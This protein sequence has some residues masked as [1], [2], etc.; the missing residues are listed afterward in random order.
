MG[1]SLSQFSNR[2]RLQGFLDLSQNREQYSLTEA[3]LESGFGS[4]PQFH[5]VFRQAMNYSLAQHHR[6]IHGKKK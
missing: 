3:A 5:R 6:R 4:Y 2:Q 1:V